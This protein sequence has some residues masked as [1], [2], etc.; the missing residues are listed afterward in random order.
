VRLVL[1]TLVGILKFNLPVLFPWILK[2]V[3]DHVLAGEPSAL[4]FGLDG[5]MLLAIGIFLVYAVATYYRTTLS[6]R[7]T[8]RMMRDVRRDLFRHLNGLPLEFFHE[9]RT[10]AVCS[11]LLTDV[12]QA[13]SF[14][15]IACTN[16]L[17]ELTTLVAIGTIAFWMNA[18]LS[19]VAFSTLP[20]FVVVHKRVGA[21]L[22]AN[23]REARSRMEVIEGGLHETVAGIEEVKA[24]T[25]ERAGEERFRADYKHFLAAAFDNVRA[26]SWSLTATALLTRIPL[27]IV[28]WIGARMV[29]AGTATVGELMA[30]YAY[31]EMAYMPLGRLADFNVTLANSLA[32]IDR[33]FELIDEEPEERVEPGSRPLPPGPG[34]VRFERVTFGYAPGRAAVHDVDLELEPGRLVALAGPSG[35]G[36]STLVKLLLRL[37]DP[38]S[39]AVRIDGRDVR[40]FDRRSLR[41]RI[42]VVRQSPILF[43][44]TIED[45]IR[46]GREDATLEQVTVAA[47]RANALEFV[48]ALPDGFQTPIGERGVKLSGGQRQRIALA[49][50]FLKDAPILVLD[51]S[52]SEVDP[53]S[54]AL[55]HEALDRLLVGRS[56]LLIAHRPSALARASWVCVLRDG[57]VSAQGTPEEILASEECLSAIGS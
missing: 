9:R 4:G 13:Q 29:L 15:A 50:A 37:H 32:A 12:N 3:V 5:L 52:T 24:F 26:H 28:V 54:E 20:L 11:R 48:R 35:A 31:L 2:D 6:D 40:D 36:K 30:F 25:R 46:F 57:R 27:V 14:V 22:R 8:H 53:A 44:G 21:R 34:R 10:G 42:A 38:S 23:A 49:R 16:V 47:E 45:N 17:M 1:A 56:T 39:G 7:I 55:V 43:S 33:L 41:S 51:E 19:L 18:K